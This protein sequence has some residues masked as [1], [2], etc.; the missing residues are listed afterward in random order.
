MNRE[1]MTRN[2]V[3]KIRL[4]REFDE[5]VKELK[6]IAAKKNIDLSKYTITKSE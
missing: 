5:R 6:E 4:Y 3:R 1:Q 2:E